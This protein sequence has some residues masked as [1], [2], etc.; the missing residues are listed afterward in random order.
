MPAPAVAG[1][2]AVALP[3]HRRV[4]AAV[5]DAGERDGLDVHAVLPLVV[6]DAR[7]G[8]VAHHGDVGRRES[9]GLEDAVVDAGDGDVVGPAPD[10]G[11]ARDLRAAAVAVAAPV[12]V[13][14]VEGG[15]DRA[16][17]AE[18]RAEARRVDR[19]EP[20]LR[21]ARPVAGV[22]WY[23]HGVHERDGQVDLVV[24]DRLLHV[25][26]DLDLPGRSVRQPTAADAVD[27]AAMVELRVRA[28]VAGVRVVLVGGELGVAALEV[29]A[30]QSHLLHVVDALGPAGGLA[31]RLHRGQQERDQDRDD[32]DHD[33][34]L[35]QG[36]ARGARSSWESASSSALR[37][38]EKG[39]EDGDRDGNSP[40]DGR[41]PAVDHFETSNGS[42]LF[43]PGL[44]STWNLD[45]SAFMYRPS[46]RS[47]TPSGLAG[48]T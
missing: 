12:G 28:G 31:G 48:T 13:V 35:D 29:H 1:G 14:V 26:Q 15:R 25:G 6:D 46:R 10:L 9:Q 45:F 16:R 8:A 38:A 40:G 36:E 39:N 3:D 18:E 33:Q 42:R 32:R 43:S 2:R 34:E 23:V 30:A 22:H 27:G 11:H 20:L 4:R 19:V 41:P 5:G 21:L 37:G 47:G 44:T 24:D 7:I 17:R